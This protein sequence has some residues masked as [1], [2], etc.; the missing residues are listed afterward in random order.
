M[1]RN[2]LYVGRQVGRSG[3]HFDGANAGASGYTVLCKVLPIAIRYGHPARF[4]NDA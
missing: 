3:M 1:L 2:A 4:N